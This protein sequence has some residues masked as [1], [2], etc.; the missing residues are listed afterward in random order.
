MSNM[1][2]TWTN[3]ENQPDYNYP[4]TFDPLLGF[5]NGRKTRGKKKVVMS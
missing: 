1:W 2:Q 4:P 5:P 3:R